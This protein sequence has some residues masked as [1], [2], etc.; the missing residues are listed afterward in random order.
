[1]IPYRVVKREEVIK[2]LSTYTGQFQAEAGKV[3]ATNSSWV[4]LTSVPVVAVMRS[5]E[6][7]G[8]LRHSSFDTPS[9]S[10]IALT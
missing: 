5:D 3:W 9:G 1:M 10:C 6:K 8:L 4:P 7:R 2:S